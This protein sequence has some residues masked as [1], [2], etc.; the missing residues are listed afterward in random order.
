MPDDRP[1]SDPDSTDTHS[2]AQ[3]DESDSVADPEPISYTTPSGDSDVRKRADTRTPNT[4]L[5]ALVGA[6]VTVIT[7]FFVP[8]S[9]IL[10]GA[11]AGYL[12]GAGTTSGLRVGALSGII[13]LVPLLV[14]VP[15]V[16]LAFLLE[17]IVAVSIVFIVTLVIGF[18][19]VYTVG[20]SALGGV[21]GV[22]LYEEFG[23]E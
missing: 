4:L 12:E 20:F 10:G 14:I 17:P 22:Y 16:L 23:N 6:V 18:L 3:V 21:L 7:A 19:M 2:S 8:L 5:N 13:A 9:P 1:P 15:F 11:I